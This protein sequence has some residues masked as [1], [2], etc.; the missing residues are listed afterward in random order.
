MENQMSGGARS[1]LFWAYMFFGLLKL[2]GNV[3]LTASY[4]SFLPRLES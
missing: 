3:G 1:L 4:V 2:G